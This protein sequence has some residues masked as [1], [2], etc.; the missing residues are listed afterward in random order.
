MNTVR[1]L[2]VCLFAV[3]VGGF[4]HPIRAADRLWQELEDG[5]RDTV[6]D[7]VDGDTLT[8]ASGATVRL[9][10]I[11]TPKLPLGRPGFTEWPLAKEAKQRITDLVMN[12]PVRLFYGGRKFDRYGRKLAQLWRIDQ[13]GE[14]ELWVQ[15]ALLEMGFARV[16]TFSDNRMLAR[17]MLARERHARVEPAGMWAHGY[18]HVRVPEDTDRLIDTFQ[19]VAGRVADTAVVRGR[20]YINFGEDWHTDFTIS[21]APKVLRTFPELAAALPGY[22]GKK[23][24]VHG[25]IKRYNGPMIEA[26]HPEQIEV[27]AVADSD[28]GNEL[29]AAE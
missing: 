19:V 21:L 7:V 11:Q 10:G 6:V 26:T 2:A 28:A 3:W 24:H 16:Y 13:R 18:Y 23:I 4:P 29:R 27:V 14:P 15:G 17:Q 25:W 9:V 1:F 5:G 8:L 20:G 12:K 22:K